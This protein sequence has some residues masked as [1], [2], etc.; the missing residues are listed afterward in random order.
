MI[1]RRWRK[2]RLSKNT[3]TKGIDNTA[4]EIFHAVCTIIKWWKI[5]YIHMRER[6]KE[7]NR[8]ICANTIQKTFR[9]WYLRQMLR[10]DLRQKLQQ[11]GQVILKHRQE[12]FEIHASY[13][14]QRWWR[15]M[16][17]KNIA[18]AKIRIRNT[19]CTRLQSLW[20]GFWVRS[21]KCQIAQLMHRHSCS[22]LLRA[23]HLRVCRVS[24]A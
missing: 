17:L 22:I 20:R 10:P 14:I 21:R 1:Q 18:A 24:C 19:A 16:K 8:A 12:L 2:W 7:R 13:V 9:G 11:V 5:R 23:S 4:L 15:K 6:R 3:L